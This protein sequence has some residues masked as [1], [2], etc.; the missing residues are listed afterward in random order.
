[1]PGDTGESVC[2]PSFQWHM[3]SIFSQPHTVELMLPLC[4]VPSSCSPFLSPTLPSTPWSLMR[5][6]LSK[7]FRL[8]DA[9]SITIALS[10]LRNVQSYQRGTQTSG[11]IWAHEK[12]SNKSLYPLLTSFAALHMSQLYTRWGS[13]TACRKA[14]IYSFSLEEWCMKP[15]PSPDRLCHLPFCSWIIRQTCLFKTKS[16]VVAVVISPLPHQQRP[17]PVFS[18]ILN[19]QSVILDWSNKQSIVK[20]IWLTLMMRSPIFSSLQILLWWVT[21][22]HYHLANLMLSHLFSCSPATHW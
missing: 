7:S 16:A 3:L 9:P 6:V 5:Q 2:N 12:S 19:Q 15:I 20:P 10:M 8:T 17:P 13:S 22:L 14:H 11:L 4:I 18:H 1:M 21:N